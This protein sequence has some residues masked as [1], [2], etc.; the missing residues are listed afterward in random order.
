[1]SGQKL[2]DFDFSRGSSISCMGYIAADIADTLITNVEPSHSIVTV[3]LSILSGLSL[4][5]R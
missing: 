5:L 2:V 1:M 3:P 4:R